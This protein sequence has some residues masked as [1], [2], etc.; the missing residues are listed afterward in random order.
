MKILHTADIH[1]REYEDER[2]RALEKLIE[3]GRKERIGIFLVSGDLFDKDINAENLRPRIREVFSRSDF[4]IIIIPGNHDSNS[5]RSDMYFGENTIILSD[6]KD[7]FEYKKVR[8]C[9]IPFEPIEGEEILRRLH[10]LANKFT[11]DKKNI[12]LYHG[13]LDG[14]FF[15]RKDSGDEGEERYMPVKLSYFKDLSID[16][17]LAGHF[18]SKFEVW[19]LKKGGY[20]IYPGSPIPITKRETG[21]RKVNIFKVGEPP[22]EYLLDIPY[23]E[24]VNIEFAPL[25][26]KDPL[27]MVKKRLESFS[28]EARIIL[29]LKGYINSKEIGISESELVEQIKKITGK[30]CAE[31][32]EFEFRDVQMILEDELFKKFLDKLEQGDYSEKKKRQMRDIAI[33]AMTEIKL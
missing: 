32:P 20:F 24:E 11:P 18:H 26:D 21:P 10:F 15:S 12:L 5:Y 4:K 17:V 29:T 2:W 16:Y 25:K 19:R 31:L 1:L 9:A 13:E 28:P 27:E 33:K 8:I 22:R 14:V 6:W 7:Y 23:F 30:R 3:I